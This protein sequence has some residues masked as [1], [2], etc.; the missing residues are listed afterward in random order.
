[1]QR[2]AGMNAKETRALLD[3]LAKD[4]QRFQER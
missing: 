4:R 2:I 3:T 1:V